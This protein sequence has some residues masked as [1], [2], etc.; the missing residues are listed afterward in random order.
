QRGET[1]L[2]LSTNAVEEASVTTGAIGAE[3]GDAQSGILAFVTR[4]GGQKYAGSFSFNTDD[5]GTLWRNVGF[6]RLEGSLSGPIKGN[7]TFSVAGTV[8]GQKSADTEKDRD[9]DR[10][11]FVADGVDT[12]VTQPATWGDSPTDSVHV[13]VPRFVQYSGYCGGYGAA[14]APASGATMAQAM[15]SNFGVECQG[16]RMPFSAS[17]INT[18]SAKLQYTYGSGSRIALSGNASSSLT[19]NQPLTQLYNPS[20]YTGT[21]LTSYARSEERRVGKECRTRRGGTISNK[22]SEQTVA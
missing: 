20:A 11:I 9:L 2:T 7:L 1:D 22:N 10:P 21:S 4:A 3:F 18:G 5:M 15:R 19:R 12:V 6:N 16:L 13:A 14:A 17:G 8:T